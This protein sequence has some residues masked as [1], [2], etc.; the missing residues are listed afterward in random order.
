MVVLE[1]VCGHTMFKSCC[2]QMPLAVNI[3]DLVDTL[4]TFAHDHADAQALLIS[5]VFAVGCQ[6]DSAWSLCAIYIQV[7]TLNAKE[8]VAA[9]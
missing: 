1:V 2:I 8:L 5:P 3:V 9:T 4:G 6:A 7:E